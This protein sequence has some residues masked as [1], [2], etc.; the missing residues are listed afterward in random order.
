MLR[1]PW[2]R[3]ATR[4][5]AINYFYILEVA[6]E[7]GLAELNFGE[8]LA[9]QDHD[10]L[11]EAHFRNAIQYSPDLG[12]AHYDLA[13]VL[14]R[15]NRT[16][17]AL[18]Q[19]SLSLPRMCDPME[20]GQTRNT[21]GALYLGRKQYA[22]AMEQF[23][24]AIQINPDEVSSYIGRG[25]VQFQLGQSDNALASFSR[26]AE[27]AP[28]PLAWFWSGRCHEARGENTSP[29]VIIRL[30]P[31]SRRSSPARAHGLRN[32]KIP[33]IS[34]ARPL[35]TR[36][37]SSSMPSTHRSEELIRVQ[38]GWFLCLQINPVNVYKPECIRTM[39]PNRRPMVS[40]ERARRVLKQSAEQQSTIPS[41]TGW[42]SAERLRYATRDPLLGPRSQSPELRMERPPRY[43]R[44]S[45]LRFQAF[46]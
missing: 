38:V 6:T 29:F 1:L 31:A 35:T 19:Y 28:S 9:D 32:C 22:E 4:E 44:N 26:A 25:M 43:P 36:S 7:N 30:L 40:P 16:D 20:L 11:A 37:I 27:L 17:E 10:G 41:G 15:E 45:A 24:A 39:S 13:T 8:A 12:V 2:S 33:R 14:Q 5:T 18:M 23:D 42:Q 34:P 3:S 46:H 21:L